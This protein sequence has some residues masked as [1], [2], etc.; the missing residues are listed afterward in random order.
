MK[1]AALVDVPVLAVWRDSKRP[2]PLQIAD[3][4]RT[5]IAC[6][7][8]PVG[9]RLPATRQLARRLWVSRNTIAAAYDELFADDLIAVR[10]G[11]G[12]YVARGVRCL[13]FA[14]PDGNPLLL[15]AV[16]S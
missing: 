6:G 7:R 2:L 4:L 15:R 5:A 3:Q 9:V 8:L 13:R 11:D 16:S 10:V 1:T 14:D 12:S